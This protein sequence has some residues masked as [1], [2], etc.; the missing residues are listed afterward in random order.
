MQRV[1]DELFHQDGDG[2][3]EKDLTFMVRPVF[4]TPF[5]K[6]RYLVITP[7]AAVHLLPIFAE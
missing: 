4:E 1:T 3:V 7:V 5:L 2:D 6:A